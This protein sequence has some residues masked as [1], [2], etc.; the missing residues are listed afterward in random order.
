MLTSDII[1]GIP[2]IPK[3]AVNIFIESGS[4]G[5][6]KLVE[7]L[8]V[9][10]VSY[11]GSTQTGRI[12]AQAAAASLK[13]VGL[14]LGGKTPHLVFDSADLDAVLPVLEKS[15]TVFCGQ[16]CMT[17]SRILVQRGIADRLKSALVARLEKVR[18]GPYNQPGT[19]MGPLIDKA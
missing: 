8:A 17:G 18:P 13:R 5:A 12:I 6:R 1:S 3:G 16:F 7:S 10:V 2:E 11:T 14:E 9:R 15:S 19:D 4:D